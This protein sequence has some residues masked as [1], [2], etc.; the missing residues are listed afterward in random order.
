MIIL[1]QAM[2]SYCQM[3]RRGSEKIE[4]GLRWG[5]HLYAQFAAVPLGQEDQANSYART[6]G[7]NALIIHSDN[8]YT[9]WCQSLD[10][11]EVPLELKPIAGSSLSY[12]SVENAEKAGVASIPHVVICLK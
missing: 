5:D 8:S 6:C 7:R 1:N 2:V 4:L 12:T 3:R 11:Q 10:A 9:V